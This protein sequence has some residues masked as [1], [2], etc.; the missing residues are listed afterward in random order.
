MTIHAQRSRF[1]LQHT[2]GVPGVDF[3]ASNHLI[4]AFPKNLEV[5][6]NTSYAS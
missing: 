3:F 4:V 5:N 1:F 2:H 6:V